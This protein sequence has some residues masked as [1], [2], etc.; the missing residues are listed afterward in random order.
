MISKA[1]NR[2]NFSYCTHGGTLINWIYDSDLRFQETNDIK[3][4]STGFINGFECHNEWVL[5]H[6]L[7]VMQLVPEEVHSDWH[8]KY[9]ENEEYVQVY[10]ILDSE[11]IKTFRQRHL[12][13]H[14]HFVMRTENYV[15]EVICKDLLFGKTPF[16][17]ETAI[18]DNPMLSHPN[19]SLARH[20]E[21]LGD[22]QGAITSFE[23][24]LSF[25]TYSED[26]ISVKLARKCLARLK[27][28]EMG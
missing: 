18:E 20:Q 21:K 3:S 4:S 13:D 6:G 5:F 7:Q 23:K 28:N 17:L 10:E 9:R 2:P 26:A 27:K 8:A 15:L 1:I 25:S 14:S 24:Y 16:N 19:F 22:V 11:W 12:K